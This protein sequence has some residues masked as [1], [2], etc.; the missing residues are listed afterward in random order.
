MSYF[1]RVRP[2]RPYYYVV[3]PLWSPLY[4]LLSVEET[5]MLALFFTILISLVPIEDYY[6][7]PELSTAG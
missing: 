1:C 3:S 4:C 7:N 6:N 5:S 2:R